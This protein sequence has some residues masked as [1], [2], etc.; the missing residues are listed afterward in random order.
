MSTKLGAHQDGWKITPPTSVSWVYSPQSKC[1]A[2][3]RGMYSKIEHGGKLDVDLELN[4]DLV[5]FTA[6]RS[7]LSLYEENSGFYHQFVRSED[8]PTEPNI[9]RSI[10]D[11][12]VAVCR[13][14]WDELIQNL[15]G[16]FAED[17]TDSA[18]DSSSSASSFSLELPSTPKAQ[19]TWPL[20][21][22]LN[23]SASA[24]TPSTLSSSPSSTESYESSPEF[25]FPSLYPNSKFNTRSYPQLKLEKDDQGFFTALGAEAEAEV[26]GMTPKHPSAALLP[27]FLQQ[28]DQTRTRRK[29]S[30]SKTRA[31]VDRLRWRRQ[32][33]ISTSRSSDDESVTAS[34]SNSSSSSS[35]SHSRSRSRSRL[36]SPDHEG[37]IGLG[38]H[39]PSLKSDT[40]SSPQGTESS[41]SVLSSSSSL[42]STPP[43]TPS[44]SIV[45]TND[46][47]VEVPSPS[48]P[49]KPSTSA[50]PTTTTFSSAAVTNGS[51]KKKKS[52]SKPT[53]TSSDSEVV[54]TF[55]T[56]NE[57]PPRPPPPR[58]ARL[59][60][61]TF[62][63][64][65]E[66]PPP[67]SPPRRMRASRNKTGA[68]TGKASASVSNSK[69]TSG[70][71]ASVS[72]GTGAISSP[73]VAAYYSTYPPATVPVPGSVSTVPVP[74][75]A[76]MPMQ[77]PVSY[78]IK[79][80]M[81][82]YTAPAPAP[83]PAYSYPYAYGPHQAQVSHPQPQPRL[84]H[85]AQHHPHP[86]PGPVSIPASVSA[87][88]VHPHAHA[89]RPSYS[90]SIPTGVVAPTAM[91]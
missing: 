30:P 27:A 52:K 1:K 71:S 65:N 60:V 40:S 34:V 24:F 83:V 43:T 85:P 36:F 9:S 35:P 31:L 13:K 16:D 75:L 5:G 22:K 11:E 77:Y 19:S 73:L 64:L 67:P 45:T 61:L 86:V 76:P 80:P 14:L 69:D 54:L 6:A 56:L 25:V 29:A 42:L 23:A 47:W 90:M 7:V 91:W 81:V 18:S 49:K 4:T 46:G 88:Y 8:L 89:H 79:P 68:G 26:E 51:S 63:T 74:M 32:S 12:D 44:V 70:T 59:P 53:L 87:P 66:P 62:P 58:K 84:A 37:W 55:P 38:D 72:N 15:T 21:S 3:C 82:S 17:F 39:S 48:L 20:S 41:E 2:L 57:P 50:A 28:N 10:D 78:G 33:S